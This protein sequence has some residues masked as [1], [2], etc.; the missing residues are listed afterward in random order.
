MPEWT[1]IGKLLILIGAGIIVLGLLLLA[2]DRTPG[3]GTALSWLGKLPGDF[4]F[5]RANV[6]VY[7]PLAT[8]ILISIL[9]SLLFLVLG[10]LFRR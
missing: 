2:V 5:K 4:S 1:A 10:W 7:F 8:S 6:S 3:S 9:L